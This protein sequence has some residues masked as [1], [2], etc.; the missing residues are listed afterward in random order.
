MKK[1][2][3]ILM[4]IPFGFFSCKKDDENPA[5]ATPVVN[6][7]LSGDI[8]TDVTLDPAIEYKLTG[9]LQIVNGGKLRIPAGTVIKAEKGFN[10][11][12]LVEQGGQIFVN[13]T[14][15]KPVKITSGA[16]APNQGDWGGLIINGKA[17]LSGP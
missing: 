1:T 2:F 17:K 9:A 13:G 6:N 14:A 3:L 5:P 12:I 15:E 10:K 16:A 4:L 11:Y 8:S 7:V